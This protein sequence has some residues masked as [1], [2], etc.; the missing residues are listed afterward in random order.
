MKQLN[1]HH[2]QY[3]YEIAREGS[4]S[5]AS[6]RLHISP[7]T[8]SGQLS[9][10]EGYIGK[11]LFDRV[12]RSLVLNDEGKLV[13]EYA[14]EIFQLGNQL[15]ESVRNDFASSRVRLAVGIV[16]VV[17][18]ILAFNLLSPLLL[19]E[20]NFRLNIQEGDIES[21]LS[22]LSVN[23]I[24]MMIADTPIPSSAN[25]NAKC[26]LLGQSGVSF[27]AE[28]KLARRIGKS[29]PQCLHNQRIIVPG[30]KAILT[31]NL[32]SWFDTQD[33][34][35]VVVAE[36]EDSALIKYFGRAGHGIFCAPT[37]VEEYIQAQY[38][39]RVIGRTNDIIESFYLIYPKGRTDHP[40]IKEISERARALLSSR[41]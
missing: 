8:L 39:V 18:K 28:R 38:G 30:H 40:A 34:Q 2:L 32:A 17:P 36:I 25:I 37:L 4:I 33:I 3:F 12:G 1:Y 21:L 24:E 15:K 11:K 19:E 35:P 27:F 16:D 10:F 29:F 9:R 22:A 41:S 26:V 23:L 20:E 13:F 5:A 7:Q 31:E 6:K 14:E